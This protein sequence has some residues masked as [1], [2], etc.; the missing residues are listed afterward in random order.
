MAH[1]RVCVRVC[2]FLLHSHL[3][4]QTERLLHIV[5][6]TA[7]VDEVG[8]GPGCHVLF[9]VLLQLEGTLQV[10]IGRQNSQ[11]QQSTGVETKKWKEFDEGVPLQR[12]G[13]GWPVSEWSPLVCSLL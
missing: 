10:L 7:Q 3:P 12:T 11:K 13:P 9:V 5:V 4:L 2:P 6:T 8:V 1:H